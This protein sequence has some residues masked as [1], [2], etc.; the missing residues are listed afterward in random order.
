[1]K[2]GHQIAPR[3][4]LVTKPPDPPNSR[5]QPSD[6][7][8][9]PLNRATG[10]NRRPPLPGSACRAALR[11]QP[12]QRCRRAPSP[13]T[14]RRAAYPTRVPLPH[15][16]PAHISRARQSRC[17]VPRTCAPPTPFSILTVVSHRAGL[18]NPPKLIP[19][20]CAS[21]CMPRQLPSSATACHSTT[22][23]ALPPPPPPTGCM[24]ANS[25][26]VWLMADGWCWFVLREKYCWLVVGDWFVLR[27]K[28]CWLVADK[29]SEHGVSR[30]SLT[31]TSPWPPPHLRSQSSLGA[32]TLCGCA[33]PLSLSI[34]LNL[35]S[36][37]KA[38]YCPS[39]LGPP[40]LLL[41]IAAA[42][43]DFSQLD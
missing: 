15:S 36:F 35:I 2:L 29:P 19:F 20:A 33:A 42:P 23:A 5:C 34:S 8:S 6:Y 38:S 3:R 17:R 16:A 11:L 32:P 30:G 21:P 31:S 14:A 37:R 9:L 22:F 28:Y 4:P 12:S 25:L 24:A 7:G 10:V 13:P 27:E 41:L 40:P 26:F 39:S 1:M 43:R 18:V